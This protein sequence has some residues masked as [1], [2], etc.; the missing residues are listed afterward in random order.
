MHRV[1]TKT[2][3]KLTLLGVDDGLSGVA[4]VRNWAGGWWLV[5]PLL[6]LIKGKILQE[7]QLWV[8]GAQPSPDGH[9]ERLGHVSWGCRRAAV[10]L[11]W[12]FCCSSGQG[13]Q[14]CLLFDPVTEPSASEQSLKKGFAYLGFLASDLWR[15]QIYFSTENSII[16][17]S[18][19]VLTNMVLVKSAFFFFFFN[20][21]IDILTC[22]T[23]HLISLHQKCFIFP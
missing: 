22:L 11:A 13:L 14:E 12:G 19:S 15:E 9:L 5:A 6:F 3:W 7:T 8:C 16:N 23:C 17:M 18:S 2:L 21:I 1:C 20:S 10:G 4:L